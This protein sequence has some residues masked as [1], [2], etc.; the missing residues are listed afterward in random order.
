MRLFRK[1][2]TL[3]AAALALLL[4]A[5]CSSTGATL[6]ASHA[7]VIDVRT[8]AEYASGH[9]QGAANV[10]VQSAD[11]ATKIAAYPKDGKY[12][13][14]C[15]SGVRAGNAANQMKAMGFTDVTNAG[16]IDAASKATGLPIVKS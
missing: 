4:L 10:D 5:G 11:F 13:V 14:Y 15:Q 3:L 1:Y 12:I 16:G 6:D 9:L 7:T 8:A 2:A